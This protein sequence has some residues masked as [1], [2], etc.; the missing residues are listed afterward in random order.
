MT[1]SFEGAQVSGKFNFNLFLTF[2]ISQSVFGYTPKADWLQNLPHLGQLELVTTPEQNHQPLYDA[3][4]KA[5]K[6]ISIGIFGISSSEM[7]NQLTKQVKRGIIV[8]IICDKYCTSNTKRQ[9]IF[10]Q[11]KSAGANI[12]TATTGFSISHWKMFV[13]DDKKAFISTMNFITRTSEMRDLG[14]FTTDASVITEILKVYNQDLEN[15][16]NNT[17]ITPELTNKNLVWSPN[18]SE[19][20]LVDLINSA[21]QAIEIW[22]ENMGNPRIHTALANAA[23][24]K[25]QVRVLTSIC[26]MGMPSSQAL[27]ALK[28]LKSKGVTV[29]GTPAPATTDIPYIHAKTLHVDKQVLFLGSENFSINSLTKARELGVVFQDQ[30]I[31]TELNNLFEKDWSHAVDIPDQ[32]DEKCTPLTTNGVD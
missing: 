18:N 19:S 6:S 27:T 7:G 14:I 15:A 20:K 2:F 23:T 32:A 21:D 4:D 12:V 16:K 24:R 25:V 30:H 3:F 13:I 28:D 1:A 29:K 22:I 5:E 31:E 26:G 11:L 10:D 8:N 17:N 9:A